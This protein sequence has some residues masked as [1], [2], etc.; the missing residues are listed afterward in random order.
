VKYLVDAYVLSEPTK[1]VPN[2][3]VVRWLRRNELEIAV[4]AVVLGEL[5]YGILL[6]PPGRRRKRLEEWFRQGVQTIQ[7]LDFDSHVAEAWAALLD[8]LRKRGLS[9]PVKDSLIAATALAHGLTMVT[10]NTSDYRR[11][12]VSIL[13]PFDR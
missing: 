5:R 2:D 6:L 1:P 7:P 13:N 9:M 12:E 10:R 8:R 11:S 4:S 3:G